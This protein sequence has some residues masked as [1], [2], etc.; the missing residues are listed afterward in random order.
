MKR[1]LSPAG[2]APDA[3]S[4]VQA[5]LRRRSIAPRRLGAPAPSSAELAQ[6]VGVALRSPD[7][8]ALVPWRVLE[9]ARAQR[10]ALS[11]LF[12]AEKLR[13]DPLA[14]ADDLQRARQH[15]T[16]APML[17]AFVVC[18]RSGVTV[19][20]HEQWLAAGA[21]LGNLLNAFDAL[22]YG[23]IVL[24]GERCADALLTQALGL[25]P[26]EVLAGFVSAGTA[27][28]AAPVAADK[29]LERVLSVWG[30]PP[31]D[32]APCTGTDSAHGSLPR[33]AD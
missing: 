28:R 24:S 3:G 4:A 30:G 32:A 2:P 26:G 23:A 10:P 13:R 9:L 25:A 12:A 22:G 16:Q 1:P 14:G 15:A 7:H 31:A 11:D 6:A 29:P 20:L 17:L 27:Q 19:P 5:L 33:R 21:A 18:P 8:G